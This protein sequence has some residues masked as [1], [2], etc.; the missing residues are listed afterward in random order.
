MRS[1]ERGSQAAVQQR[2]ARFLC[3]GFARQSAVLHQKYSRHHSIDQYTTTQHTTQQ[4]S[5]VAHGV[6]RHTTQRDTTQ[7]NTTQH[8]TAQHNTAHMHECAPAHTRARTH[9]FIG[10]FRIQNEAIPINSS[11]IY[12]GKKNP[13]FCCQISKEP[14]AD[15]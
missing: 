3:N 5:T 9:S 10:I 12:C 8:S 2:I 14:I 11:A 13:L 4:Y 15:F 1:Q 6:K 7:Y